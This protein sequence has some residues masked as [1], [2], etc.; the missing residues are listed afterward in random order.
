MR[1]KVLSFALLAAGLAAPA[2]ASMC[3]IDSGA[4]CP[5]AMPVGGYCECSVHGHNIGGTIVSGGF[6]RGTASPF[7]PGAPLASPGSNTGD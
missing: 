1:L 3:R 6:S 2:D 4:T 5:S 7:R